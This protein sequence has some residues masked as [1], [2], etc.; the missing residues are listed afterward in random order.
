MKNN[1][2]ILFE[3]NKYNESL[4][5]NYLFLFEILYLLY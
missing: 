1:F 5:T 2:E 3:N 4:I